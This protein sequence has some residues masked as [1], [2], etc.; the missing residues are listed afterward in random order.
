MEKST[1]P[2]LV[3]SRQLWKLELTALVAGIAV[4]GTSAVGFNAGRLESATVA[5]AIPALLGFA[6][7]TLAWCVRS[8]RC[9]Q[10]STRWLWH[11]A[12]TRSAVGFGQAGALAACPSCGLECEAMVNYPDGR[13]SHSGDAVP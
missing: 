5:V 1:V 6:F 3:A 11:A 10:C 4:L 9:P 13:A 2:I 12:T 7:S 8:V